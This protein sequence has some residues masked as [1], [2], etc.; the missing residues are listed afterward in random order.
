[1]FF[2]SSNKLKTLCSN[3]AN[4]N[5]TDQAVHCK[6]EKGLRFVLKRQLAFVRTETEQKRETK[7]RELSSL[8]PGGIWE[9]FGNDVSHV[10]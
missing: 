10:K 9:D 6:T 3:S 4:T 8:L 1:M 7:G 5:G 2:Y